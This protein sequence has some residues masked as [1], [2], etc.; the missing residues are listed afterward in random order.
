MANQNSPDSIQLLR[1]MRHLYTRAKTAFNVRLAIALLIGIVSPIITNR[2][3]L[4]VQ[5]PNIPIYFA[6][7][8]VLF[9]IFIF[10]IKEWEK[11]LIKTAAKIQEEFDLGLFGLDWNNIL[12]GSR[13]GREVI[14]NNS[15]SFN[16][17]EEK[18]KDW[19]SIKDNYTD[20][21]NI[22]LC[23]RENLYWDSALKR[24]FGRASTVLAIL[25]LIGGMLLSICFDSETTLVSY[26]TKYLATSLPAILTFSELAVSHF[27]LAKNQLSKE[28][29][30]RSLLEDSETYSPDNLRRVQDYIFSSRKNSSVV[31]DWFY[32]LF[33]KN[34]QSASTEATEMLNS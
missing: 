28:N 20:P 6:M 8:G 32:F 3:N 23:Q 19:Y 22:M 24:R 17:T 29:E 4:V 9:S 5:Y 11:R 14:I 13:V 15:K 33:R 16:G 10:L 18:L 12:A 26:F 27:S 34:D 21:K 2:P 31:P 7:I 1:A 25:F 30:I